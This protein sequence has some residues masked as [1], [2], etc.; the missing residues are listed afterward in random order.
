MK[1]ISVFVLVAVTL[2]SCLVGCDKIIRQ[3]RKTPLTSLTYKRVNNNGGTSTEYLFDFEKNTV[4]RSSY[5]PMSDDGRERVETLAEFSEE[6]E[7]TL[8]NKLYTYGLF[9]IKEE[10]ASPPNILDGGS[11]KLVITYND[12]TSKVSIG[13]NN[14]P[15]SV[16]SKCAIPFFDICGDGVL[17]NVP[18]EYYTPPSVGCYIES[19]VGDN[20]SSKGHSSLGKLGNYKWNGFEVNSRDYFQLNQK[21]SLAHDLDKNIAYTLEFYAENEYKKKFKECIV[22]SYDFNEEMTGETVVLKKSRVR[23]AEFALEFDKIYVVKIIFSND[24][25]AEYT[26]NTKID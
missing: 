7:K 26:F 17:G 19:K 13:S 20:V 1:R 6:Q 23:R 12:G 18:T 10:Y 15:D 9:D 16:F 25:F 8:I 2:L 5:W 21:Y 22:I 3:Y 4:T 24:D 11:W 14:S